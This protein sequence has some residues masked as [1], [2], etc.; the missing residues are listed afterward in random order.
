MKDRLT[1]G[2]NAQILPGGNSGGVEQV[3]I[4]LINALGKLAD[5]E[6]EYIVVS[7]PRNPDWLRPYIA[8]NMQ[9]ISRP[10]RNRKEQVSAII[11]NPFK[12]LIKPIAKPLLKPLIKRLNARRRLQVQSDSFFNSLSIN[13]MHFPSQEFVLTE[14]P[15]VYNPHDLQHLHFPEFFR[16]WQI[17]ARE[18]IYRAGCHHAKA[19]AVHSEWV[20]ADIIHHYGVDPEK[21]FV[22]PWGPPT[23]VYESTS[24]EVQ[25]YVRK[26]FKLP[27]NFVFYPAQTWPHKNHIRL[28]EAI[29]LLKKQQ[30][31]T[32]NLICTGKKNDFWPKI[33]RRLVELQLE[34]QVKFLGFV[35]PSE[36]RALYRLAQFVVIPTLFEAGS[37]PMLEAWREGTPVA[38]STVTSLPEQAGNSAILFNPIS[39]EEIKEAIYRMATNAELRETLRQRGF[40]RI[41][42]FTW[43]R[44]AKTYRALYRKLGD[45]TLTEEDKIL[46]SAATG[47]RTCLK[48]DSI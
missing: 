10:W 24:K 34:D 32:I 14:L 44:T 3:F 36:L 29:A 21:I 38:C 7:H 16:S 27:H 20:K 46:L 15:S 26:K 28:L 30:R 43:E 31:L 12:Q 18:V 45:W 42:Q 5:G 17:H 4:G 33:A 37:L 19:I 9:V 40:D 13:V 22:I 48:R 35:S 6:E 11:V 41:K 25:S 23:D 1:I 2:I 8:K 39:I 47:N